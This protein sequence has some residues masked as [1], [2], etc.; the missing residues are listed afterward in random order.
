[1][2]NLNVTIEGDKVIIEG[3]DKIAD[4]MPDAVQR[5][6]L[7]VVK[8]IHRMAYEFLSGPGLE[9]K[10]AALAG[11]YPVPVRTGHL[12]RMLD[13]LG[14]GETK[15]AGDHTFTAGPMEAMVY[16]SAEYAMVIHEGRGSS[17]KYGRRPYLEDALDAFNQGD[18]IRNTIAEEIDEEVRRSGLS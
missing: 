1:M 9:A 4:H 5:G 14:P 16:N 6:L 17:E 3:L 13:W 7:R 8:G 12:R 18:R 15:T 11:G 2:L 10:G